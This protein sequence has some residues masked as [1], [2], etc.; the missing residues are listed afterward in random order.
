MATRTLRMSKTSGNIMIVDSNT[1]TDAQLE[2]IAANPTANLD[3]LT[4]H[5][6]FNFLTIN[7]KSTLSSYTIP[8][9]DQTLLTWDSGGCSVICTKL[10]EYGHLPAHIYVADREFGEH[11]RET[12]PKVYQ[13][14]IK[15]ATVVVDW[16]EGDGPNFMFWIR[17]EE[18]RHKKQQ[19]FIINLTKRIALPWAYHMAHK[20]GYELKDNHSGR[21]IMKHGMAVS[22]FAGKFIKPNSEMSAV[23]K[24]IMLL[25]FGSYFALLAGVK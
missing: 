18:K 21:R 22:K 23:S 10:Y 9:L 14:Y 6:D 8:Q 11:I 20:M 1:Y 19:E 13:D 15:W 7:G 17:D 25:V 16:M 3:K 2:S 5:T 4:F 12:N 24:Y